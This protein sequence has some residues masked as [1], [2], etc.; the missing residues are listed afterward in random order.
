M[1]VIL[2]FCVHT[3][4]MQSVPFVK[5]AAPKSSSA[6]QWV[7]MR[8][9]IFFT[10]CCNLHFFCQEKTIREEIKDE[11]SWQ[12]PSPWTLHYLILGSIFSG[13]RQHH[14]AAAK[15]KEGA[16]KGGEGQGMVSCH[17]SYR[18]WVV[19]KPYRTLFVTPASSGQDSKR[20][21]V[22]RGGWSKRSYLP[23]MR[24]WKNERS[25]SLPQLSLSE[26]AWDLKNLANT[27]S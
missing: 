19:S 14:G 18:K 12:V 23:N 27:W 22:D 25:F 8:G 15:K 26:R 20:K 7:L 13:C 11:D 1:T 16:S 10:T 2:P 17:F 3:H 9:L 21:K 4:L 6:T 24:W 5:G